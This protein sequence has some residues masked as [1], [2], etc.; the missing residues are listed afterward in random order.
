[1]KTKDL[2][3]PKELGFQPQY[4]PMTEEQSQ[5]VIRIIMAEE[6]HLEKVISGSDT[7]WQVEMIQKR[8]EVL[9]LPIR[10]K[11]SA[12]LFILILTEG[13]PGKMITALIDCLIQCEGE[14]VGVDEMCQKV[15]PDGFY[16]D[17]SCM[18]LIDTYLKPKK[19]KWS[20]IY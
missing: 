17:D 10:L 13:N 19:T 20:A 7:P 14:E 16:T 6:N 18:E 2:P 5:N 8:I 4:Q 1:M 11:P 9:K 3:T 15:Y 12:L